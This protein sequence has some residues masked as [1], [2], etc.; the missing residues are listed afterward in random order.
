M[1]QSATLAWLTVCA[2]ALAELAPARSSQRDITASKAAELHH[3]EVMAKGLVRTMGWDLAGGRITPEIDDPEFVDVAYSQLSLRLHSALGEARRPRVEALPESVGDV[4]C[5]DLLLGELRLFQ[6]NDALEGILIAGT[7]VVHSAEVDGAVELIVAAPSPEGPIGSPDVEA[8]L[9]QWRAADHSGR[10]EAAAVLFEVGSEAERE[11]AQRWIIELLARRI[12]EAAV[13]PLRGASEPDSPLPRW[14]QRSPFVMG[15]DSVLESGGG[16]AVLGSF[17]GHPGGIR[18]AAAGFRQIGLERLAS[19]YEQAIP[20]PALPVSAAIQDRQRREAARLRRI[21]AMGSSSVF[22]SAVLAH[23]G[24][25][26]LSAGLR[27]P[28]NEGLDLG[29]ALGL[30]SAL[31]DFGR[32]SGES[33]GSA[34]RAFDIARQLT[35]WEAPAMA[36]SFLSASIQARSEISLSDL[37]LIHTLQR[38]LAAPALTKEAKT[39][40]AAKLNESV[41]EPLACVEAHVR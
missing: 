6:R 27:L 35:L 5:P 32:P 11:K 7:R 37:I 40:L 20:A 26:R 39:E 17:P 12:S 16:L 19:W 22:L 31:D 36:W 28:M 14:P 15:L 23:G 1:R 24:E 34:E 41:P 29:P 10:F 30:A 33:Y 13:A 18:S 9:K 25:V 4:S 3:H 38:T 2:L 8:I 21:R